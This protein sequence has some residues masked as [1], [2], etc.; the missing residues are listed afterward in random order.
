[1]GLPPSPSSSAAQNARDLKVK[2]C[3]SPKLQLCL[4]SFPVKLLKG[5]VWTHLPL[6]SLPSTHRDLLSIGA[7]SAPLFLTAGGPPLSSCHPP[8]WQDILAFLLPLQLL[9]LSHPAASPFWSCSLLRT[10]L[11]ASPPWIPQL[12]PC[13]FTLTAEPPVS[14]SSSEFSQSCRPSQLAR[15]WTARAP[16]K[17]AGLKWGHRLSL[18]PVLLPV[19]QSTEARCRF[20]ELLGL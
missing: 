1:M 5:G 7:L 20:R 2:M 9:L 6:T 11:P 16:F 14:I 3:L 19:L 12:Q 18:D 15:P 13:P 4:L 10:P 8:F 17:S